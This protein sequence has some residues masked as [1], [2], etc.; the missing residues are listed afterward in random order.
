M[1]TNQHFAAIRFSISIVTL[2]ITTIR[3][4]IHY[5]V[6][7]MSENAVIAYNKS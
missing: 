3:Y 7:L 4:L 1:I 2:Y 5:H 6:T